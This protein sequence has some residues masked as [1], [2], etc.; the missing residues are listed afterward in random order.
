MVNEIGVVD[1]LRLENQLIE[2]TSLVRQLVVGQ[3][4]PNI[5]ARVCG[6]CTSVEHPTNMCP[7]LQET[8]SNYPLVRSDNRPSQTILNPRGN[9]SAITLRSGKQ[10]PQITPQQEPRPTDT[11][12]GPDAES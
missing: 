3:H 9:A 11:D 4:Q 12:S 8:E 5:A 10:L 2:L 1:N 7:T 6:I